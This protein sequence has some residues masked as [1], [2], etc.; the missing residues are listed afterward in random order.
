MIKV[1][2]IY[3]AQFP[4]LESA[5]P[6]FLQILCFLSIKII[7]NSIQKKTTNTFIDS[8][9]LKYDQEFFKF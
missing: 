1:S 4:V 7:Q 9:F 5:G 2:L 6:I 3:S 8:R